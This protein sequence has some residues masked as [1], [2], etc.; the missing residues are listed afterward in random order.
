MKVQTGLW[1]AG[2]QAVNIPSIDPESQ[3]IPSG[4]TAHAERGFAAAGMVASVR[5]LPASQARRHPSQPA[6]TTIAPSGL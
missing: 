1:E 3:Y 6:E 5:P 2:S 4:D